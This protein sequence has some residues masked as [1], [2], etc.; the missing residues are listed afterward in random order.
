MARPKNNKKSQ[1][2]KALQKPQNTEVESVVKTATSNSDVK[3]KFVEALENA[4]ES[5]GT[6]ISSK[7]KPI[8][9]YLNQKHQLKYSC[10]QAILVLLIQ[11]VLKFV[12]DCRNL[13]VFEVF[14][15]KILAQK[16]IFIN[17]CEHIRLTFS[18]QPGS[19]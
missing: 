4:E 14:G 3:I 17:E 18:V 16:S 6:N 8:F 9:D 13:V 1:A 19:S 5:P 11:C 12:S 10:W 2:K 15:V 7:T